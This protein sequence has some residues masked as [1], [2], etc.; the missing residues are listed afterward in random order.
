MSPLL[1]GVVR[2]APSPGSDHLE[3]C[4]SWAT[5]SSSGRLVIRPP[6]W[7]G[8]VP[9]C[10][11]NGQI[12][13]KAPSRSQALRESR[14][15]SRRAPTLP[16]SPRPATTKNH[17]HFTE[18]PPPLLSAAAL[19]GI[20]TNKV[21]WSSHCGWL[22]RCVPELNTCL[23]R[24]EVACRALWCVRTMIRG[25]TRSHRSCGLSRGRRPIVCRRLRVTTPK[26]PRLGRTVLPHRT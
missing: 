24:G 7:A 5:T 25:S 20:G 26:F 4:L 6:R 23:V 12:P 10:L 17:R 18:S 13:S 8:L 2:P 21:W 15:R 16:A 3:A 22:P 1:G 19:S 9:A 14:Q 11:P